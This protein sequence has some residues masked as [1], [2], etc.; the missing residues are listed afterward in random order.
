MSKGAACP[1]SGSIAD[2]R[3]KIRK[4]CKWC[5]K[6]LTVVN[7]KMYPGDKGV[8]VMPYHTMKGNR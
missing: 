6:K 4:Y 2:T 5:S 3:K 8:Y 7:E 1:G